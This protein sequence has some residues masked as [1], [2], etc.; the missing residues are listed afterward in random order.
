ML[1]LSP[2]LVTEADRPAR[3]A[4]PVAVSARAS[5]SERLLAFLGRRP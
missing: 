2:F 5:A 4:A 1:A 3:F